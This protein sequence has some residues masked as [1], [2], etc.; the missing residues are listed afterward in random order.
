MWGQAKGRSV[1]HGSVWRQHK[2][3]VT[4]TYHVGCGLLKSLTCRNASD[5]R[6]NEMLVEQ[7]Q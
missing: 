7:C 6:L 3:W 1:G 2:E 4:Y 5:A